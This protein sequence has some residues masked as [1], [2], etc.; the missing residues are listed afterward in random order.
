MIWKCV[1]RGPP[2]IHSSPGK[3]VILA[4]TE[5]PRGKRSLVVSSVNVVIA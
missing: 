2:K 5:R 3:R 4:M 1:V